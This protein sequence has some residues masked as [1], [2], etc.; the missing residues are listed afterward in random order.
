MIISKILDLSG[1]TPYSISRGKGKEQPAPETQQR[2]SHNLKSDRY[3]A[4]VSDRPHI[5]SSGKQIAIGMS[6]MP[7]IM[8]DNEQIDPFSI[9]NQKILQAAK[10]TWS[11]LTL[12]KI[13]SLISSFPDYHLP[14][15]VL[16]ETA[17]EKKIIKIHRDYYKGV[18]VWLEHLAAKKELSPDAELT[19]YI[20]FEPCAQILAAQLD[21][22]TVV[23]PR[24][25]L[26]DYFE[27]NFHA[28]GSF[29]H[30]HCRNQLNNSGLLGYPLLRGKT[31]SSNNNSE[32]RQ[33]Y[34]ER[35]ITLIPSDNH[36]TN[37]PHYS[38][39][40]SP[41]QCLTDMASTIARQ[42]PDV[43]RDCWVPYNK[44]VSKWERKI[45]DCKELQLA[46]LLPN[47]NLSMTEKGKKVPKL[48]N[49]QKGFGHLKM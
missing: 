10:S 31:K 22:I 34:D 25:V 30:S 2:G 45:R 6:T 47:G 15:D 39:Y 26:S 1:L 44:T 18:S 16:F 20:Y 35:E 17:G 42:D 23:H 49:S 14:Q 11:N 27:S 8:S 5:K 24:S 13:V 12:G 38:W 7:H 36:Q 33:E 19:N 41:E 9:K 3:P 28:W 32:L 4:K 46:F 29:I 21:L 37:K 43:D 48:S 40:D